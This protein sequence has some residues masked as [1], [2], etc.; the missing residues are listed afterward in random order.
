MKL[1]LS[2]KTKRKERDL[3]GGKQRNGLMVYLE[4]SS[5]GLETLV[6]SRAQ[7]RRST[8]FSRTISSRLLLQRS[9]RS[10][11]NR[12]RPLWR[13]E[14]GCRRS[15]NTGSSRFSLNGMSLQ[16]VSQANFEAFNHTCIAS[17]RNRLGH[18]S[19]LTLRSSSHLMYSLSSRSHPRERSF[20]T[21][22]LWIMFAPPLVRHSLTFTPKLELIHSLFD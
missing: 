18:F 13:V 16:V 6:N 22:T 7:C 20:G 21:V 3:N 11:S 17:S 19:S 5:I 12:L 14:V 1:S 10:I 2:M 8:K 9:L 4:G 15:A